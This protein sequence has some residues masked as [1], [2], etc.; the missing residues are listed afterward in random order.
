MRLLPLCTRIACLLFIQLLA[1]ESFA[2]HNR[3]GEITYVQTGPLTIVATITTYTRTSSVQADRDSLEIFWGDGKDEWVQ[4]SN[5]N[6]QEL[7]NDTKFN[8]Y[9]IEHTYASQARYIISMTDPNR[10]EGI[11]NVNP[12]S[13][14]NIPFHLEATV[15]LFNIQFDGFNNSPV[16]L[17][18][19]IDIACVGQPFIHNPNA[20]DP[21]GDSLAY[22][23]IVPLQGVNLPVPFY[24]FPSEF[25]PSSNNLID[26][27]RV[28]GEF[29]WLTPQRA[30]EYNIAMHIIQFRDGVPLDTMIRD[31][32]ILVVDCENAPPEIQT[33]DQICVV[34]GEIIDLPVIATAP[35]SDFD[36]RVAM[37]ALGGPFSLDISPARFEVAPGYRAQPLSGRFIWQ[38]TC[39]H[40]SD[41]FYTVV[42]RAVD[43]FPIRRGR[44]TLYL[45]TLHT[46]RIKVVGPPPEDVQVT[47]GNN[48]VEI[49]WANP[50]SCED[51][52]DEYFRGFSVWRRQTS[53]QF[54]LDDC[55]PGLAGQGYTRLN[56][57]LTRDIVNDRYVYIDQ[58]V[59]RGRT[60][61]YRVLAEFARLSAGGF[62]FNTVES[63]PSEEVCVQ[64]S[65][66]IPLLTKVSVENTSTT[67][68]QIQVEW[69]KPNPEDLDTLLNPG[70]YRYQLL[71]STGFDNTDFVEI[72]GASFLSPT[73]SSDVDTFFLDEGLNTVDNAYNYQVS[74]FVNGGD[75]LLGDTPP[76]SSVYLSIAS[77]D[78]TN[79]LSWRADVP[80]DNF[81]HVVFRQNDNT[82]LFD[83]LAIVDDPFYEDTGLVNL[84]EYC[85]RVETV[86]SYG[87]EGVPEP[88]PNLSQEACGSPLDTMPPCPPILMVDNICGELDGN[89]QRDLLWNDLSWTNPNET[90]EDT[91][92]V[93][94]YNV[95]FSPIEGG[96]FV[97]IETF[98]S[99]D[100][101]LYRHFPDGGFA[102]CYAVTAI[103]SFNNESALSNIVCVDN[104]PIYELPNVFTPNEDGANDRFIPLAQCFVERV[105]F[106]V[107]NRWGQLIYQTNDPLLNWDGRNM[108]GREVSEGVYY[109]VCKYFEQRVAGVVPSREVL[110]GYI[111]LLR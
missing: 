2:T 16:L 59:D 81:R 18:P 14:Q 34:A 110:S 102:G 58:E 83:T 77:S 20:Y 80:W 92:D 100:S 21:D 107:F 94:G 24:S 32:Q 43:D 103:D 7:P 74:F 11:L 99:L 84:R 50:Y 41:Q 13:S 26:L 66:D 1:L 62:P 86:G 56:I 71:R 98:N 49:S 101:L 19:P 12:P 79:T 97:T 22:E 54:P 68:G 48:E 8:I 47:P 4:R 76:A 44:D 95:Y 6:G 63:L 37:T 9:V 90:C 10:N 73:F 87:I 78:E 38:T 75:D 28:T 36:Q 70:P 69:T 55:V 72:P 39:E 109:Y 23:L 93:I 46:L 51:A 3:A 52:Q 60:Y 89:C 67:S 42:F 111:E 53:N 40:I 29:F 104:C 15:T 33:E 25:P 64:L 106:N 45:S 91:D 61:C 17:Q 85:Y 96:D 108:S 88:L 31:M 35:T 105:E 5:G 30:G 82:G 65:R 57:I 27:N